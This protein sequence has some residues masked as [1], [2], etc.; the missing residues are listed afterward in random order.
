M[1]PVAGRWRRLLFSAVVFTGVVGAAEALCRA[2]PFQANIQGVY[3]TGFTGCW[4]T[5]SAG[6]VTLCEA[7]SGKWGPQTFPAARGDACRVMFLGGSSVRLPGHRGWPERA[8]V[9]DVPVEVVNLGVPG[10]TSLATALRGKEALAYKPDVL[11]VYEGHNDFA[12]WSFGSG[13]PVVQRDLRTAGLVL[14]LER[15]AFFRTLTWASERW[16]PERKREQVEGLRVSAAVVTAEEAPVVAKE[17]Q[18][19]FTALVE[20]AKGRGVPVIQVVPISNPGKSPIATLMD[21]DPDRGRRVD[22]AVI[23]ADQFL[24]LKDYAGALLGADA[25][26][27]EDAHHAGAWWVKA[28]ALQALGRGPEAVEAYGEA[29]TWDAIPLRST[30]AVDDAIRA[31]PADEI[32][33]LPKLRAE[34]DGLVSDTL[35]TDMVH[36]SDL[37]H[38]TLASTM[39]PF[40]Q[41][42][43]AEALARR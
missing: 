36:F 15:S 18:A 20:A 22:Q 41:A 10:A 33:D 13:E 26:L 34:D 9:G 30:P 14:Q 43:C 11:V 8:T 7:D 27:R 3:R 35:F 42:K 38:A 4:L 23:T 31:V 28:R 12:Q 24:E 32:V 17:L 37:G 25:A 40:I 16:T 6:T 2:L 19:N 29:R 5:E 39:S 1:A 21:M